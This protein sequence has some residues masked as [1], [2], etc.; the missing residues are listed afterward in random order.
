[1]MSYTEINFLKQLIIFKKLLK[2]I[3][4]NGESNNEFQ[5]FIVKVNLYI[6]KKI[7]KRIYIFIYILQLFLIT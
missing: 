2:L 1:M 7:V 4:Q 5:L 6:Y 3:K